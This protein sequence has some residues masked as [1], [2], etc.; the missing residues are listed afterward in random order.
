M[1]STSTHGQWSSL[2]NYILVTTGAI[3]GLGNIFQ[4][5][6]FVGKFGGLFF[7]FYILCELFVSI[8]IL[9]AEIVIG[10]R[11]KQNPVG[12]IS[13]LAL[14]SSASRYWSWIGWLY[15]IILFLTL[16]FYTVSVAFPAEYVVKSLV[17]N[18]ALNLDTAHPAKL[19]TQFTLLEIC[20]VVFLTATMLVVARGINRGLETISR[21]TVPAYFIIFIGLA[22]YAC[23]RGNF[24]TALQGLWTFNND[25][26]ALTVLFAALTFAFFKLNVGMGSMIVYGSYLPYH[27][28]IGKSTAIIVLLDA[29]ISLL[30]YFIVYPISS[31]AL[32]VI[33][34]TT[35]YYQNTFNLF[36]AIPAGHIIALLFF[37]AA[38]LAAWTVSIA[39]AESATIILMERFNLRRVTAACF[40]GISA[41]IIGTLI[42]RSYDWINVKVLEEWTLRDFI[43]GIPTNIL[44]PVTA[45]L[46]AI[47]AG[48]IVKRGITE[49]ELGFKP[50]FYQVWLLLIRVVAPIA[51]VG[52]GLVLL[53]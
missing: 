49:N 46:I 34:E 16:A 52:L 29:A 1:K 51:I 31:D 53:F 45:L 25:E 2:P 21:L 7:L 22:I 37:V 17:H 32:P 50:E 43:I 9:L 36:S 40:I 33:T 26:S 38:V 12:A 20:F 4:F 6:Y 27:V 39:I 11:G 35:H 15:F 42:A 18:T 14:E 28:S 47:F 24:L 13:I 8:P 48:W 5:P 23:S 41:L 44:T 19:G 10:R 3:V 30:A